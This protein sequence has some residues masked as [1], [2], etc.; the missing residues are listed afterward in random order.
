MATI[1]SE[2]TVNVD[3]VKVCI[4]F[5]TL[6]YSVDI[7]AFGVASSDASYTCKMQTIVTLKKSGYNVFD[8]EMRIFVRQF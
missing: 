5:V 6:T 1:Q 7:L 4:K 2:R 3:L 8:N